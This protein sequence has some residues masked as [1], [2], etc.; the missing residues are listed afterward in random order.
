MKKFKA[1]LYSCNDDH[2]E[3]REENRGETNDAHDLRRL[4]CCQTSRQGCRGWDLLG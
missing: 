1:N 4:A 2:G 3:V